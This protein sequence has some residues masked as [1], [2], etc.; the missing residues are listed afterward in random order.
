MLGAGLLGPPDAANAMQRADVD[1]AT[2]MTVTLDGTTLMFAA[3]AQTPHSVLARLQGRRLQVICASGGGALPS[4]LRGESSAPSDFDY[5]AVGRAV[6]WP[7]GATVM[8]VSLSRDVSDLTDI[9]GI[10]EPGDEP[11][12]VG[13]FDPAVKRTWQRAGARDARDA[14]RQTW[15]AARTV[16]ANN[17]GRLPRARVL[18]KALRG[19][20]TPVVFTATTSGVEMTG[21]VYVVGHGTS[22]RS[23]VLA[24]KDRAGAVH[25]LQWRRGERRPRLT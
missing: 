13:V 23:L 1:G 11:A 19:A 3:S 2:H 24:A 21:R 18:A 7:T 5:S 9:C 14:L 12:V 4:V 6:T 22:A 16:A 10:G 20:K 17:G 25:L 15:T 8:Q